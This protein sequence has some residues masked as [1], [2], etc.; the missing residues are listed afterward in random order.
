[1]YKIEEKLGLNEANI[2]TK[3]ALWKIHKN[4]RK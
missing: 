2:N 1:M 4:V 3:I